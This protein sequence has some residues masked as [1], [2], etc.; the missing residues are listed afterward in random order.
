MQ[1][2][3]F[4]I[5]TLQTGG[6]EKSLLE[7]TARLNTYRP[8]VCTLFSK[9]ADLKNC[10]E[11]KGIKIIELNLAG[12]LWFI[13]GVKKI[14]K[15]LAEFNPV[16]VHANLFKSEII[17]RVSLWSRKE[18]KLVGSLVGDTYNEQRYKELPTLSRVKLELLKHID[19]LTARRVDTFISISE[20]LKK[21][22][23]EKLNIPK[24]KVL[25]IPRGRE[26]KKTFSSNKSVSTQT[27]ILF[28]NVGRLIPLKGQ[29]EI[30]SAFALVNKEY[31]SIELKIAGD[32][33]LRVSLQKKIDDLNIGEKVELLGRV[34]NVN[35]WLDVADC[36]IFASHH[37]GQGGALVEAMLA[38]KTILASDIDVIR[39]SVKENESG[40]FF[41]VKDVDSI[42]KQMIWFINN[43][44]KGLELGKRAQQVANTK[45]NIDKVAE[46]YEQLYSKLIATQIK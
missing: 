33:P 43:R 46:Q 38:G 14:R 16:V 7:I 34:D 32:G 8:I 39:E 10:F 21:S 31:S 37:E 4:I 22:Y 17:S 28:L 45:F 5:D 12:H 3:L 23:V 26:L 19:S 40:R 6:A 18:I 29:A 9:K 42:A 44:E 27:P 41:K 11:Q 2:V 1:N 25:V 35:D 20:F 13:D 36:F 15:L 24:Q 30:I